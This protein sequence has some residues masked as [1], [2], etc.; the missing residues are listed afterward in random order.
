MANNKVNIVTVDPR[1]RENNS[2]HR[3]REID[4]TRLIV[5]RGQ[6][7]SISVQCSGDVRGCT[8]A[9][10]LHVGKR[11]EEMISVKRERGTDK[12]WWFTQ[13]Y[14]Y[15][16]LLLT[17]YSPANAIVSPY[18]LGV[19]LV[20]LS[21]GRVLD[22]NKVTKF[23]LLYNPW[24]KDDVVYLPD[25]NLIQEYVM[26]ENG[27]LYVGE[28]D[29][30]STRRWNF[31]QFEDKVMD[32][33][34]EILDNS[35]EAR[36][37]SKKD[38][39]QR[40]DPVYVSRIITAMVNSNRDQGVLQGRWQE[41]YD[42]GVA[43][44]RWTGSV[45]I[46]QKWSDSGAKPVK[47]GQCWVF[48][49]V[50]CTV[51]RC[52]GIPTRHVT[53]FDSAHDTD[54]NLSLDY[55]YNEKLEGI[56]G[57]S[58][59][60]WN[61][62]CW[63]ESWMKRNDL[64]EGNDG[65]Q[66]LDPTPQEL[67]DGDYRCGPCPVKAIKEGNLSVK[68]DAPFIFAEVNADIVYWMV[69]SDGKRQKMRVNQDSTGR[70]ISTKSVFGN[71]RQDITLEYKYPEGSK[72]EREVYEKAQRSLREPSPERQES[73]K[74]LLSVKPEQFVFGSEV[75]IIVEVENR[76]E[77]KADVCLTMSATA[78]TYNN[79]MLGL[80]QRETK[81]ISVPANKVHKEVVSVCYDDYVKYICGKQTIKLTALLQAEGLDRP[82]M[83]A[84]RIS[85]IMPKVI[86]QVSGKAYRRQQST[87]TLSFTNPLKVPLKGGV[88]T[89]E[90]AGL[91]CPTEVK[92]NSDIGPGQK[93]FVKL[94]FN[95]VRPGI[96]KLLVDFFSDEL[97]DVKG[98]AT[99]IVRKFRY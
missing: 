15:D 5:R 19:S 8:A 89:V 97:K 77:R 17:V 49:A 21:S 46:L 81:Q 14:I 59:S 63:I 85:P 27:I 74:L 7:F 94:A 80:L 31:G 51:L 47:Y 28:W 99:V 87:C 84:G 55:L 76:G 9:L 53:N 30:I 16:E 12:D 43:P 52:L 36:R 67:S 4:Q 35:R 71:R 69:K 60:S 90:G 33:C 25:E 24:C 79:L 95:P 23:H 92:V 10:D 40:Y 20:C 56:K 2:A 26:N 41:P 38:L 11:E 64:P 73:I 93:A 91:L 29:S 48:A 57:S 83:A 44:Y 42:G 54:G 86:V 6:S 58:D 39:N 68:Y 82:V 1:C 72:K 22:S 61:Y 70:N 18:R 45:S 88:F 13:R 75:K 50:A 34:F 32:I 62:H 66:V 65:W 3:T 98:N 37:D 96:R 78:E